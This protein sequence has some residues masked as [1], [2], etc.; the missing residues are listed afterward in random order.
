MVS[1]YLPIEHLLITK[2]MIVTQQWRNLTDITFN[3]VTTTVITSNESSQ[4]LSL[5][6]GCT[7][8]MSFPWCSWR[9]FIT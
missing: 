5:L 6:P 1:K 4:R 3:Q 2:S 8:D 9:K 7:E